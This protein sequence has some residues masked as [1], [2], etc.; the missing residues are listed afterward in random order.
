MKRFLIFP[1]D[2][3][4]ERVTGREKVFPTSKTNEGFYLKKKSENPREKKSMCTIGQFTD[5][6]SKL[7]K[8][9]KKC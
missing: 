9:I 7:V 1:I 2:R 6:R 8:Y 5:V 3:V 4:H